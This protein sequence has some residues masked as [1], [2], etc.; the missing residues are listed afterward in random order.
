MLSGHWKLP[1]IVSLSFGAKR[2]KEI[3]RNV[4]GITDWMLSKELKDLEVNKLVTRTVLDTFPPTV[5]YTITQHARSLDKL[6]LELLE[7]G[8]RHR[9]PIRNG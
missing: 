6:L 9:E 7:W 5:N 8:L 4:P 1:I 2:F 3:S